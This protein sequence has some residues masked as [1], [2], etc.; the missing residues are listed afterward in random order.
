M[1]YLALMFN[2]VLKSVLREWSET[3]Y[4]GAFW[5]L[6]S[7][8]ITIHISKYKPRTTLS[9]GFLLFCIYNFLLASPIYTALLEMI[10]DLKLKRRVFIETLNTAYVLIESGVFLY[11]FGLVLKMPRTTRIIQI[12]LLALGFSLLLIFYISNIDKNHILNYSTLLNI[13]E[14]TLLLFFCIKYFYKQLVDDSYINQNT[15]RSPS[16]WIIGGLFFYI[17]GSLLV[18]LTE[19]YLI[20]DF[21][22]LYMILG[23]FHY[24]SISILLISIS[25]AFSCNSVLIN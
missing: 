1:P 17:V 3:Y 13:I 19:E 9:N 10:P 8:A 23:A 15:Q 14:L 24:F 6:T 5:M 20:H 4:L 16:F 12:S 21:K 22:D 11:Y 7:L 25:K 18:M 2:Q